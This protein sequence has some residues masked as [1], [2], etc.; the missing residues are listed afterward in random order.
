MR[1]VALFLF[2]I[3][4]VSNVHAGKY[5]TYNDRITDN[6]ETKGVIC[7]ALKKGRNPFDKFDRD[8]YKKSFILYFIFTKT[9]AYLWY[10][11]KETPLQIRQHDYGRYKTYTDRITWGDWSLNRESL[12]LSSTAENR[13]KYQCKV[14]N[15]A[16]V[17]NA[18]AE[19]ID[20]LTASMK[21]NKL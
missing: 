17:E 10:V 8:Y 15:H 4:L 20:E 7:T 16:E 18:L 12:V 3:L 5:K 14:S 11:T 19:K 13:L 21:K 2:C 9:E 6:L 1:Y